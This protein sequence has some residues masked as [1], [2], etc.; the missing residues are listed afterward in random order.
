[1]TLASKFPILT[2]TGN[3][4]R[5]RGGG[6]DAMRYTTE[7]GEGSERDPDLGKRENTIPLSPLHTLGAR[8]GDEYYTGV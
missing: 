2:N 3:A 8:W 7:E 5:R 4:K 1:M 6:A